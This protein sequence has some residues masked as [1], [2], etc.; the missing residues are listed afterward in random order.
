MSVSGAGMQLRFIY[1]LGG[2]L[3]DW[4]GGRN[5]ARI[6]GTDLSCSLN[7]R[8]H[9]YAISRLASLQIIFGMIPMS[10]GRAHISG[11]CLNTPAQCSLWWLEWCKDYKAVCASQLIQDRQAQIQ[12]WRFG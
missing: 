7:S 3:N 8:E 2:H 9:E 1:R 10:R 4:L 12:R 5:T 6:S 11:N